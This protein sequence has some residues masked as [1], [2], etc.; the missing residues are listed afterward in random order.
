MPMSSAARHRSAV[1]KAYRDFVDVARRSVPVGEREGKL[2]EVRVAIRANFGVASE[3]EQQTLLRTLV[4]KVAFLRIVTPKTGRGRHKR[5]S[6]VFV[7]RDGAVVEGFG[8]TGG[9]RVA[10]GTIS[11]QEAHEYHNRLMKRQYYGKKPPPQPPML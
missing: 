5:E 10:D 7:V 1:L 11:M 8:E 4:A 3:S 6:G 9:T 2:E